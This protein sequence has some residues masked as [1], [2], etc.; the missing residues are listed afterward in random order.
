[1]S[2]YLSIGGPVLLLNHIDLQEVVNVVVAEVR[3]GVVGL[4]RVKVNL[5]GDMS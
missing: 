5:C 2:T 3:E 4:E 1:M